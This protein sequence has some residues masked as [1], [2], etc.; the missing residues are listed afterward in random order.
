MTQQHDDPRKQ[1]LNLDDE[2]DEDRAAAARKLPIDLEEWDYADEP[3]ELQPRGWL[4]GN[5]LC[6]Q[7]LT[8]I[9]G[10]GATGKTALLIAM[11][12]S[13]ATGRSDLLGE[14]VFLRCTVILLCFEDGE[15]ELRRRLRAARIYYNISKDDIRGRL[16]IKAINRSDLK[17][18]VQGRDGL[19]RGALADA[20]ERSIT[21][22]TADVVLL[23]PLV[24]THAVSEND[25]NAMDFVAGILSGI[26]IKH[27]IAGGTPQH[28]RKGPADP[29][30][31]DTGRG[32]GSL[33]DAFRLCFTQTPMQ[34]GDAAGYGV[35]EDERRSLT[36][37]DFGKVN[38]VRNDPNARWFEL[39]GVPL[40]NKTELYPHG[41]NVQTIRR[42]TPPD[43][44][45][46]AG[47][48]VWNAI[49][50]EIDKGL[51]NGQR[52][53]N[54]GGAKAR[55][56]WPVV[57]RHID[58]TEKQARAIIAAWVKSGSLVA[59]DYEDPTDYKIRK[60]LRVDANKRPGPRI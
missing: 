57:T 28:T 47:D 5:L 44:F 34:P 17:L 48:Q 25:N 35:S 50:D 60:G 11:A 4:L 33:K 58:R 30:N 2:D 54:D 46:G 26:A 37:L 49:L 31:A 56:A 51:D 52:Y 7:F 24:K 42:W 29:G 32:A 22:R 1:F 12:L 21:R 40:G 16:F 38:L 9:F 13:L 18:A 6:R 8:A 19:A 59:D 55:A 27:N 10:D 53:S 41:D 20:L 23:D 3:D 43:V 15:E 36:R 45:A 39:V 14:H